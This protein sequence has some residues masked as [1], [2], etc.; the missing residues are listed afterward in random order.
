MY[1]AENLGRHL[2]VYWPRNWACRCEF[3]DLFENDFLQLDQGA[4]SLV[5]ELAKSRNR[6]LAIDTWRLLRLKS[7]HHESYR[8][9][10]DIHQPDAID[11]AY[12]N[13]PELMR[14][15][16][17]NQVKKLRPV[18]YIASEVDFFSRRFT[19]RTVSVSIRSWPDCKERADALFRIENVYREMDKWHDADFFVS[20]DSEKLLEQLVA[21]YG[22]RITTYPKR[23]RVNDR[24]SPAGMQDILIDMMLLSKNKQLV[25]SCFSTYPEVAW[26]LGG[27]TAQVSYIEDDVAISSWSR[28]H[29]ADCTEIFPISANSLFLGRSA[30][31]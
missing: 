13:I 31:D 15:A 18:R 7:D 27:C 29:A 11:F 5:K 17:L 10:F 25:A 26:W 28:D 3:A 21:R 2:A 6:H 1:V 4:A 22:D 12:T 8:H 30:L 20:C 19:S 14:A 24:V 9:P 16:Y 23:T